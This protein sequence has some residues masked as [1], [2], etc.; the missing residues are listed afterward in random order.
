M[1]NKKYHNRILVETEAKSIDLTKYPWRAP[2]FTPGLDLT[3]YPWRAPGFTPGLD[4]TKYPWRAPGFT[5]C[6]WW[7]L[8]CS[9][10]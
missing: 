4:L 10:F 1:K 6:F 5:P 2:G 8:C 7:G 3:K 9:S